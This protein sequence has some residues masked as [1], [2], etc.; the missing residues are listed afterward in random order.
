MAVAAIGVAIALGRGDGE[1]G[2]PP[3]RRALEVA[4]SA[5]GGG[6]SSRQELLRE[7]AVVLAEDGVASRSA[8]LDAV[9]SRTGPTRYEPSTGKLFVDGEL[10]ARF[11]AVELEDG[12]WTVGGV[13]FCFPPPPIDPV[14]GI[15]P[16]P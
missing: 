5:P 10:L 1:W 11:K 14:P 7:E 3:E 15:T 4:D 16:S 9:D 6:A 8:L 12:T 13:T 2:C